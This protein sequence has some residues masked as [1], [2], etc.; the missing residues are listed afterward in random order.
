MTW[1]NVVQ[2]NNSFTAAFGDKRQKNL[3]PHLKSVATLPSKI[4]MFNY[5]LVHACTHQTLISC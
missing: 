5:R 4:N 3:P 2:F 1:P